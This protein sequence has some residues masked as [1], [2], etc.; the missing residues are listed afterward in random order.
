MEDAQIIAL[1]FERD[2]RAIRETNQ[3]YGAYC[4]TV[5]GRILASREDTEECVSDTWMK[6]WETIPPERPVYF[7]GYLAKI[8]RNL[9][10]NRYRALHTLKRGQGETHAVIDELAEV[11]GGTANVESEI[12]AKELRTLID[13]FVRALPARDGNV[14]IRRYFF[15]ETPGEIGERYGLTPGNVSVI[16]NRT[17]RKLKEALGAAGY[18]V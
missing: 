8:V 2:E 3:K 13:D 6:T 12:L 14:F 11:A 17:R 1:Y 5:A 18:T 9:A 16:L 15:T 10:I 4:H 7:R